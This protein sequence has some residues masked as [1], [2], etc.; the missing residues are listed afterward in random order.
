MDRPTLSCLA[1]EVEVCATGGQGF[2]EFVEWF[3]P[4][5][6]NVHQWGDE[7]LV[8]TVYAIDLVLAELSS[9]LRTEDEA[10]A[11]LLDVVRDFRA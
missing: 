4:S 2:R 10:K 9:G 8:G 3:T 11:I 6:W 5:F 1:D 7:L